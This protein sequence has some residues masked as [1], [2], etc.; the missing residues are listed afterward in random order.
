MHR[1]CGPSASASSSDARFAAPF[2]E[3]TVVATP[4]LPRS[5]LPPRTNG[6]GPP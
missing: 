4:A 6:R 1:R 3:R 2:A 5:S